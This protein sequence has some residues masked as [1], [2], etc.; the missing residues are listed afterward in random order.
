MNAYDILPEITENTKISEEYFYQ[1]INNFQKSY[2][3]SKNYEENLAWHRDPTEVKNKIISQLSSDL[4][5]IQ[6][7]E[8]MRHIDIKDKIH[9]YVPT[10]INELWKSD[11]RLKTLYRTIERYSLITSKNFNV[12]AIHIAEYRALNK[13]FLRIRRSL[14]K[15]I[16]PIND[17]EQLNTEVYFAQKTDSPVSDM[18]FMRQEY[19]RISRLK[20]QERGYAFQQFLT[21]LF[22]LFKLYPKDAFRLKG[23]EIDGSFELDSNTYLIEAKWHSQNTIQKDLLVFNGKVEGKSSWARGLLISHAGFSNDC[24]LA[25]SNGRRTSIIGMDGN[26]ISIV[27]DGKCS[28]PNAVRMKARKAAETNAFFVSLATLIEK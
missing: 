15:R 17:N 10:F 9:G 7:R 6:N 2:L 14:F 12:I 1:L 25:F 26:D 18:N 3:I 11:K 8:D 19:I 13:L 16:S 28:L 4:L 21:N 5:A 20:P 22:S 24:L 23:E 27:L